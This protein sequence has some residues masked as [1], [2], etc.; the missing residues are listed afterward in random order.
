M[1]A[2]SEAW[3]SSSVLVLGGRGRAFSPTAH[4]AGARKGTSRGLQTQPGHKAA[5]TLQNT[6][7]EA[8]LPGWVASRS[9]NPAADSDLLSDTKEAGSQEVAG[10]KELLFIG[11]KHQRSSPWG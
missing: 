3:R 7:G 5:M 11:S 9:E 10:R 2:G 4:R 6:S 1:S 8:G